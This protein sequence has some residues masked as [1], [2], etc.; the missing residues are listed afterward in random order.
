M[1]VTKKQRKLNKGM[2]F[3][4]LQAHSNGHQA[5]KYHNF[6]GAGQ[7]PRFRKVVEGVPFVNPTNFGM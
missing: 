3:A 4:T 7:L 2:N 6:A 1:K 5:P